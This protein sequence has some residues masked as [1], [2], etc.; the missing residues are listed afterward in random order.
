MAATQSGVV[1]TA[2]NTGTE[3]PDSLR[4]FTSTAQVPVVTGTRYVET[5]AEWGMP[6]VVRWRPA[7]LW[8]RLG[9][10][11]TGL[12]VVLGL[13]GIAVH[14]VRPSAL[15]AFEAG[16]ARPAVTHH[17]L[18]PASR[19]PAPVTS[20]TPSTS[21]PITET[22]TGPQTGSVQVDTAQYTVTVTAQ[23]RCWVQATVPAS[24]TPVFASVLAAGAQQTLHPSNGQLDLNLG[25]SGV[26]VSVTL[27]NKTTSAW[28][29]TPPA[30][31]FTLT[32]TSSTG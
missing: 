17:S 5:Y 29:F 15:R 12:L 25:A 9:V 31:P 4:P 23:N 20:K 16:T 27:A 10:W 11:F 21:T 2:W 14:K 13:A 1:V 19:A 26:T 28:Q 22:S 24:P 32:F 30:A 7:P 18:A 8:L 3:T 6:R